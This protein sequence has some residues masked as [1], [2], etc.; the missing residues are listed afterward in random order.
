V[1][2]TLRA[3]SFAL[4]VC[5][6]CPI[7]S[8]S[9][10]EPANQFVAESNIGAYTSDT[11]SYL[12]G[13]SDVLTIATL[14]E[15]DLTG[16]FAV[17]ADLTF[18]YPLIGPVRAGGL[19]L[20]EVEAEIVDELIGR[21]FYIDPQIT[22]T[23]EAYRNQ[24]VFVVGEVGAPGAYS[25][26]AAMNLGDVLAIAGS[27]LPS[28]GGEAVIVPAGHTGV[29]VMSSAAAGRESHEAPGP[30]ATVRRV[31]IDDLTDSVGARRVTLNDGDT[32]FVLPAEQIY[33]LG[34]VAHPGAYPMQRETKTASDTIELAG[35]AT[36]LGA[37]SRIEIVRIVDGK[38][39]KA[40]G[41]PDTDVLPGDTIVVPQRRF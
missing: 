16:T 9:G 34:H 36:N 41:G 10:Q 2:R 30:S 25:V 5:G 17:G 19:T 14:D 6:L 7:G 24:N 15:P 38:P 4:L 22:V 33:V 11:D 40:K 35:G 21:G 8:A 13:P 31:W 39:K 12:V 18:S 32:V 23:V 37:T 1:S 28:A 29:V 20:R 26:S 27:T 3:Y